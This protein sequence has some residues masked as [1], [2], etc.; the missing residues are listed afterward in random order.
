MINPNEATASQIGAL[1]QLQTVVN[2][3]GKL[4]AKVVM[5]GQ[6]EWIHLSDSLENAAQR[7]R[8]EGRTQEE[9]LAF[10]PS[11]FP[12]DQGLLKNVDPVEPVL[13]V[14]VEV[15]GAAEAGPDGDML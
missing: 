2:E 7:C 11:G 5:S 4:T 9:L 1:R 12:R 13:A 10:E 15:L 3:I 14:A 8:N 6:G